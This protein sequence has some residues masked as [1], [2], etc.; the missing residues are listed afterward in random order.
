MLTKLYQP[1]EEPAQVALATSRKGTNAVKILEHQNG[2]N[3]LGGSPFKVSVLITD[4]ARP[5]NNAWAIAREFCLPPPLHFDF[6]R[7]RKEFMPKTREDRAPYFA[8]M[9]K[10]IKTIVPRID[11]IVLAGF[12]L[13]LTEPL[14]TEFDGRVINVHP[15]NLTIMNK[16]SKPL[17][18]GGHAVMDAILAGEKEIR[19]CTHLVIKE[20][21]EGAVLL[22]SEPVTVVLPGGVSA[23]DLRKHENLNLAEEI[24]GKHQDELKRVGDW[25]IFPQTLELMARGAFSRDE[26]GA[27]YLMDEPI[28][29]GAT[30]EAALKALARL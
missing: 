9:T 19:S 20:V 21:D 8:E 30:P 6:G 15:A 11:F 7:F 16:N 29:S 27:I 10:G 25:V 24:A 1:R 22:V 28:P 18:T 2:L 26:R 12:E 23:A 13:I 4:N 5:K 14:L 17:F 3:A